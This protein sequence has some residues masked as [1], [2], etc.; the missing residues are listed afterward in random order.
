MIARSYSRFYFFPFFLFVVVAFGSFFSP[1]ASNAIPTTTSKP[2][3]GFASPFSVFVVFGDGVL[4]FFDELLFFTGSGGGLFNEFILIR[5]FMHSLLSIS[6]TSSN[7]DPFS[8]SFLMLTC[9][10]YPHISNVSF[11]IP[12]WINSFPYACSSTVVLVQFA[13]SANASNGDADACTPFSPVDGFLA[14][15]YFFQSLNN[16]PLKLVSGAFFGS[17]GPN[18]FALK[19]FHFNF[20]SS[21]ST[22]NHLICLPFATN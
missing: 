14:N 11:V 5:V 18:T 3:I 9:G 10:S 7:N 2:I 1:P 6:S 20:S 22:I 8:S 19:S 13:I 12:C 16:I 21:N 15:P 17:V 4:V